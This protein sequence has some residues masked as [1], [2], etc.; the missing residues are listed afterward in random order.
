MW[1]NGCRTEGRVQLSVGEKKITRGN[2]DKQKC[3]LLE[4][5]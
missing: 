1:Y 2:G 3:H 4:K 5:C